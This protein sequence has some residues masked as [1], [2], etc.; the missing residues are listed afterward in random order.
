M[1]PIGIRKYSSLLMSLLIGSIFGWLSWKF[2]SYSSG[3]CYHPVEQYKGIICGALFTVSIAH[4][5]K[6]NT[7]KYCEK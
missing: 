5:F 3:N 6:I 2:A 7:T 1:K 4:S